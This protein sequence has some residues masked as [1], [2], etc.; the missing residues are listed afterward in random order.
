MI[1]PAVAEPGALFGEV[2][3]DDAPGRGMHPHIGHLVEPLLQLLIEIIEIVEAAAEEEVLA[4][5]AIRPLDLPLRLRPVRLARLRQV[6]VVT[7]KFEQRP[8]GDN[9][10]SLR[11]L[12]AE[13]GAHAVVEDVFWHTA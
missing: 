12:A 3:G 8:I 9:V 13:H 6:A 10:A 4:D 7:G 1:R 11:I 2:L 5:V